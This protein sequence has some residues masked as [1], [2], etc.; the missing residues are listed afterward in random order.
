MSRKKCCCATGCIDPNCEEGNCDAV[1]SDCGSLGP[2]GFSVEIELTCR[3]A[4]CSRYDAGPGEKCENL[5]G[6]PIAARAGCPRGGPGWEGTPYADCPGTSLVYPSDGGMYPTWICTP[7]NPLSNNFQTLFQWSTHWTG[8]MYNCPTGSTENACVA[9]DAVMDHGNVALTF[10]NIAI[11][12][13]IS[14]NTGWVN[15]PPE[16]EGPPSSIDFSSLRENRGVFGMACG[17]CGVGANVCCDPSII[18]TP[19]ACD[20]LGGGK[21]N[22]QLLSPTNDPHDGVVYGRI[23]W[24]AP[25]AGPSTI[26]RLG[27]WCGQGCTGDTT[28][29][30]SMF[31]LE[32]LATYAVSTTPEKV[33]TAACPDNVV[34]GPFGY[35]LQLNQGGLLGTESDGR[36]WRYEQRHVWV[37]FKHCNDMYTGT[38]NKCRMQLGDYIPVRTGIC[39]SDI[40]FPKG[41]C[42]Y[43]HEICTP[44]CNPP[45]VECACSPGILDLM[46]RAGWDFTKVTVS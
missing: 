15:C 45:E 34:L 22:Y 19:C 7:V 41:C 37:V 46:R 3:P 10:G 26:G 30:S 17:V 12:K 5:D 9:V 20:C 23:A 31:C 27:L 39:T 38:G 4:S 13:T 1:L 18:V 2:L 6:L 28:H 29:R 33:P 44:D 11:A 21:T 25:C 36:V 40:Y 42:D 16:G 24:F 14:S 8:S 32:I 35:Y 43:L